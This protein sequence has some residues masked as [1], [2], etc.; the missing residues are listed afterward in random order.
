MLRLC[1]LFLLS[2][3]CL[4]S[5]DIEITDSSGNKI[6]FFK[7]D[8]LLE[9]GS[10]KPFVTVKGNTVFDGDSE[11]SKDILLLITTENIFSK[12]KTGY[13][14]NA[15]QDEAVF[16]IRRGGFFFK[17]TKTFDEDALLA[18]YE[19]ADDGS[20]MLY[21]HAGDTVLCRIPAFELSTGK[22]AA[23]FYYFMRKF[24]LE[25]TVET[26][27]EEKLPAE[28][29]RNVRQ[30]SGSVSRL[31]NTGL[32]EFVWDGRVFK[33]KWNSF[34]FEE[35][36]FDGITLKRLWYPGDEE[37]VWDGQILRR[38][39]YPSVD[40]FE[41]NGTILRRRFGSPADEFIIQGNIVKRYFGGSSEDEWQI[42]GEVPIPLI[43]LVVFGLLRK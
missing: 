28:S 26:K 5:Q 29:G 17:E 16:T 6:L 3:L 34:D 12:K 43:A 38:K 33:R 41:W 23:V 24:D 14:L 2:P 4:V 8:Q 19:K 31:W 7:N 36:T 9:A 11:D 39:W 20:L 15:A 21:K 18:Y 13:A 27:A 10:K 1:L 25:K 40:E 30:T 37:F 32:D 22:L 35:W 42:D